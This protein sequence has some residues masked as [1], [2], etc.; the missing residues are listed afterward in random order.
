MQHKCIQCNS[1]AMI[2]QPQP[3]CTA[4][5]RHKTPRLSTAAV[6]CCCLLLLLIPAGG[7]LLLLWV[8][9]TNRLRD[10]EHPTDLLLTDQQPA[11][12]TPE[13]VRKWQPVYCPCTATDQQPAVPDTS[14]S[15]QTPDQA[16]NFLTMLA[17]PHHHHLYRSIADALMGGWSVQPVALL[18]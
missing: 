3:S 7:T 11:W 13:A 15:S 17:C 12:T 10:E 4:Q 6:Y 9:L 16:G 2:A 18:Y 5:H 14:Q 1:P 8:L